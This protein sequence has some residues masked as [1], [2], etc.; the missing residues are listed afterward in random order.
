VPIDEPA[1]LADA[2]LQGFPLASADP[3]P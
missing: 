1:R 3:A 2:L